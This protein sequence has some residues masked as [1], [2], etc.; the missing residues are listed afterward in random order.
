MNRFSMYIFAI[1]A[2]LLAGALLVASAPMEA[3]A[4]VQGAGGSLYSLDL[5][6]G[7]LLFA[8]AP[9][10]LD[11]EAYK[12][13]KDQISKL[14]TELAERFQKIAEWEDRIKALEDAG[15]GS[16]DLKQKV[17]D[18]S[19][20][21][22]EIVDEVKEIKT[23]L[24]ER[25]DEFETKMQAQIVGGGQQ[26]PQQEIKGAIKEAGLSSD[27]TGKKRLPVSSKAVTNL[28]ASGGP[29]LQ[30]EERPGIIRP[31]EQQ[32]TVLDLVPTIPTTSPSITYRRELAVTDNAGYQG[33]QGTRKGE[34]DFTFE[35]AQ[36]T[37][38]TIA[39][40]VKIAKQMMD[41]VEGLSA[42]INSR[43]MYLLRQYAS[44]EVLNGAGTAGTLNGLNT[45]ATAFDPEPMDETQAPQQIDI[46]R[47]AM[48]QVAE[49]LFPPTGIVLNNNDWALI[50]LKKDANNQYLFSRPQGTTT[51]RLW[52]LPVAATY[53]QTARTFTVG[54]FTPGAVQLWVRERASVVMSTENEDDFVSNLIT[55]L[56]EMR[57]ALTVYRPSSFVTGSLDATAPGTA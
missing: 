36:E 54:S 46:L 55:L 25:Q 4:A 12:A 40:F 22:A 35:Q 18:A 57:A 37:V 3:A 24:T 38:E 26:T 17:A 33:A 16:A 10:A 27:F 45:Q 48:A 47:L 31:G 30:P 52:G 1:F 20:E 43:L 7:L 29:L 19:K 13:I 15:K 50:E 21:V 34:S 44:G 56:A 9:P 32:L 28:D 49:S 2:C 8:A 51:P 42:Y 53:Q 23:S 41:D 11:G 39:H 14:N 6:T 5:K